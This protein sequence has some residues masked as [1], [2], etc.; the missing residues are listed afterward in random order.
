MFSSFNYLFIDLNLLIYT[1]MYRYRETCAHTNARIDRSDMYRPILSSR[2]RLSDFGRVATALGRI[3]K[4]VW[5]LLNSQLAVK[6]ND[7][8]QV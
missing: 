6:M 3:Q 1:Y 7:R 2:G 8:R 5:E 4:L